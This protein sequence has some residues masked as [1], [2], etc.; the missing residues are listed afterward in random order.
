ME[1]NVKLN[2][3]VDS[4][5]IISKIISAPCGGIHITI[6]RDVSLNLFLPAEYSMLPSKS[7]RRLRSSNCLRQ[8]TLRT[9]FYANCRKLSRQ[10]KTTANNPLLFTHSEPWRDF[11]ISIH[12]TAAGP[13]VLA[14]I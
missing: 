6:L 8:A 10:A 12:S 7:K 4:L 5:F 14:T 3:I 1:I 11:P 9:K 2:I 13:R